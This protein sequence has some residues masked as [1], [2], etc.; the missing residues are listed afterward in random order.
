[1]TTV[2][3]VV[4]NIEYVN[5]ECECGN[6]L[7]NPTQVLMGICVECSEKENEMST[8]NQVPCFICDEL[9]TPSTEQYNEWG[10]SGRSF[11]PTDWECPDCRKLIDK[12]G[13]EQLMQEWLDDETE[14]FEREYCDHCDPN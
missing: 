13:Q 1:M 4:E 5:P 12:L 7:V 8:S 14:R 2:T 9:F 3:V 10:N 11:D 6:R